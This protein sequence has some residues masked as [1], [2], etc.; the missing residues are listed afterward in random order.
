MIDLSAHKPFDDLVLELIRYFGGNKQEG[1]IGRDFPADEAGPHRGWL[2]AAAFFPPH[3]CIN[4]DAFIRKCEEEGWNTNETR[5]QDRPD[6][7]C[8]VYLTKK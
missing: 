2:D 8:A 3:R 1:T 5:I 7:R 4:M 6:I